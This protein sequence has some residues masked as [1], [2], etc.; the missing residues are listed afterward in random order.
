MSIKSNCEWFK[1][2]QPSV[3]KLINKKTYKGVEKFADYRI[4]Y[5]DFALSVIQA[6]PHDDD[7]EQMFPKSEND[8]LNAT[9]TAFAALQSAKNDCPMFFVHEGLLDAARQPDIGFTVDLNALP[10]PYDSFSFIFPK[11]HGLV[12]KGLT[13]DAIHI[14]RSSPATNEAHNALY[15]DTDQAMF[16]YALNE[17][18]YTKFGASFTRP[19]DPSERLRSNPEAA[20]TTNPLVILALN[21]L[22]AMAARP[23]YVERGMRQGRHKKS[24][25]EIWTPNIVG[26]KYA[27]KRDPNA[28]TGSHA[29][30]RMHWRR[31]HFRQQAFGVGRTEHKIIWLEPT[32]VNAKVAD[33]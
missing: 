20:E 11:K 3:W 23:E 24:G 2:N 5:T 1:R 22:F 14:F 4:I 31:G 25:A 9:L 7:R 18:A 30:P 6:W 16:I 13:I 8:L 17:D 33:A 32:L 26:R 29:S 28:E 19:F 27:V 12:V 21:L 15:P 10:L